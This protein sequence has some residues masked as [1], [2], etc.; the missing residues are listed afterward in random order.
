MAR[1]R[2]ASSGRVGKV[3]GWARCK[4]SARHDHGLLRR[5]GRVE[6]S[7]AWVVDASRKVVREHKIASGAEALIA[8][9]G[10]WFVV[11]TAVRRNGE[12]GAHGRAV[13]DAARSVTQECTASIRIRGSKASQAAC[14]IPR[15]QQM[16][17]GSLWHRWLCAWKSVTT[18]YPAKSLCCRSKAAAETPCTRRWPRPHGAPSPRCEQH[19]N[20][21]AGPDLNIADRNVGHHARTPPAHCTTRAATLRGRSRLAKTQQRASKSRP[22]G[23]RAGVAPTTRNGL[24]R[25]PPATPLFVI[26][27][28]V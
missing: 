9:P 16:K 26:G 2:A 14:F 12:D 6:C 21:R 24:D 11:A 22:L 4:T 18:M 1:S 27:F 8:W 28:G 3:S 23:L 7:S 20:W 15:E 5:N 17:S 10:V 19:D 13:G 25:R